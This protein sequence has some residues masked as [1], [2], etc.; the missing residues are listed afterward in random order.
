MRLSVYGLDG[1][2]LGI[3]QFLDEEKGVVIDKLR[4]IDINKLK[5]LVSEALGSELKSLGL[6]FGKLKY[7]DQIMD[8]AYLHISTMDSDEYFL[9]IYR[10]SGT[11]ITNT[12]VA[13]AYE[14][15]MQLLKKIY[16]GIKV[17]RPR[18]IGF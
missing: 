15:I 6:A 9:E 17:S 2:T 8:M 1:F 10:E 7:E 16:P 11:V 5:D 18:L 12:S 14:K 4:N 13:I 3:I